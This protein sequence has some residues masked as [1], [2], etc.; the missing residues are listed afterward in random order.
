VQPRGRI[1][2]DAA[3]EASPARPV[4]TAR[5]VRRAGFGSGRAGPGRH[6]HGRWR[7]TAYIIGPAG[8]I[9]PW[10][11]IQLQPSVP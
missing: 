4:I 2:P 8:G 3:D 1:A 11:S 10:M 6:R 5:M 9:G 7:A